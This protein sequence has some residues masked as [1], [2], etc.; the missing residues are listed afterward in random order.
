M[1]VACMD[2]NFKDNNELEWVFLWE[3]KTKIRADDGIVVY[4][5]MARITETDPQF[6]PEN[7]WWEESR[8]RLKWDSYA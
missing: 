2:S 8:E 7:Q 3:K 6:L 5:V 1:M 4:G